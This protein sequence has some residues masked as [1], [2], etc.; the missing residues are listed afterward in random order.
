MKRRAILSATT[1]V[2]L[3]AVGVLGLASPAGA[4]TVH[5]SGCSLTVSEAYH[6]DSL[7]RVVDQM[8]ITSDTCGSSAVVRLWVQGVTC[9]GR[10]GCGYVWYGSPWIHGAGAW[11]R[12]TLDITESI[13]GHHFDFSTNGG[14]TWVNGQF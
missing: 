12:I 11:D 5:G 1:G 8:T 7:G 2:L 13:S 3:S 6:F 10:L 4:T 9:S 14:K